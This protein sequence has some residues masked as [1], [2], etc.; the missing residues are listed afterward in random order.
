M[1]KKQ[2]ASTRNWQKARLIGFH[3]D[4]SVLTEEEKRIVNTITGL[5]I[6]LLATWDSNSP[7]INNRPL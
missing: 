7:I 2:R 3:L 1:T 5:R 4:Y 6:Q